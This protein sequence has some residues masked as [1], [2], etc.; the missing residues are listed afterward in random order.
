MIKDKVRG[1]LQSLPPGVTLVAATKERSPEQMI[2][3]L[4]SGVS[5]FGENYIQEAKDKFAI[6]GKRVSWHLIGHLQKNKA[7]QAVAI[8]DMIETLDSY[9]LAQVLDKECKKINKVMPV[10]IEINSAAEPQKKGI[11]IEEAEAFLKELKPFSYL[12]PRGLMTMGPFADDPE[13][14][15]PYFRKIKEL[16]TQ[17]KKEFDFKYLSMGMSDSYKVAI[18]EGANIIRVGTAIFGA[19]SS[20]S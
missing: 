15:R 16:F 12:K 11:L 8:F 6:I 7:R 14:I 18:E 17:L 19:R 10:L 20:Q 4:E 1:L 2:E 9:E 5:V 3:A 13:L